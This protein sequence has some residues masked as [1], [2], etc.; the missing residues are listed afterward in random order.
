MSL[1][2][3][4]TRGSEPS[5]RVRAAARGARE[6]TRRSRGP[7]DVDGDRAASAAAAT[8]IARLGRSVPAVAS[9]GI[10]IS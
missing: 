2:H 4:Q 5:S 3:D 1:E 10:P 6:R 9:G 7:R 8:T